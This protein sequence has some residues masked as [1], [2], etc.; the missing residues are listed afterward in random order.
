MTDE[1]RTANCS[2]KVHT[3]IPP[4][5][6]LDRSL[7]KNLSRVKAITG[8]SSDVII[9]PATLCGGRRAGFTGEGGGS[10]G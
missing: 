7:D 4:E 6:T 2:E 1:Q 5:Q 9:K 10:S 8:G 3:A